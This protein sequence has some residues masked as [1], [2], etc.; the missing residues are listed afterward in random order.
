ME[1]KNFWTILMIVALILIILVIVFV[2]K[3]DNSIDE[4]SSWVSEEISYDKTEIMKKI[5]WL[6]EKKKLDWLISNANMYFDEKEYIAALVEYQKVLKSVPNDPE[7][8]EKVWSIY[9]KLK[10]YLNAVTYYS[11]I[12]DAKVLDK[13]KAV[14]ALINARWVSESN[15]SALT[16]EIHSYWLSSELDF[17]YT[18]SISCIIDYSLCR[19]NFQ[20]YFALNQNLETKKMQSMKQALDNFENFQ[21]NDLYYK[22]SFVTW[23]FYTNGMYYVALKTAE[24]ILTQKDNYIPIMKV[25]AK[26]S[27]ELWL[28][29]KSKEM[30]VRIREIEDEPQVSYLLARVYEKLNERNIA[31]VNY[32]KALKDGYEDVLDIKRRIIFIYFEAWET[33]KMLREFA[34][35]L[36]TWDANLNETDYSLAIYYNILFDNLDTAKSYSNIAIRKFPE[37]EV[38]YWYL[39]WIM[40]QKETLNSTELEIIKTNIEKWLEINNKNAMIMMCNW[41]YEIKRK[42]YSKAITLL[43][44]ASNL[45]W[46]SEY[47]DTINYRLEK[48]KEL[49]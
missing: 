4:T 46:S 43:K 13:E 16:E 37:S 18:N 17:Y 15:I 31:L 21:D 32:Q 48:A 2:K 41:I 19:A 5:D 28:Y 33:K 47:L 23:D 44:N 1:K 45:P 8:N 29:K 39:V 30:L 22:A 7:I 10:Q 20:D 3:W 36:N 11:K 35:L 24:S 42:N 14:L 25:I 12:K 38:F 27:Y 49:K 9:Y 6:K 26:S 34:E 40:L